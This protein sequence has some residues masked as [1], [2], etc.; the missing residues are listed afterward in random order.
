MTKVK[1]TTKPKLPKDRA[2]KIECSSKTFSVIAAASGELLEKF[3]TPEGAF[4]YCGENALFVVGFCGDPFSEDLNPY[5]LQKL[6]GYVM[7]KKW[8]RPGRDL[9]RIFAAVA[10]ET[11][12]A[13]IVRRSFDKTLEIFNTTLNQR[14]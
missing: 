5:L 12:R 4:S 14:G 10:L 6:Y 1:A 2:A 7:A 3:D 8:K 9:S 13:E 11:Y